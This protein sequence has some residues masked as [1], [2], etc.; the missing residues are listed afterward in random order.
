MMWRSLKPPQKL[1][2]VFLLLAGLPLAG[3]GWLGWQLLERDR[4]Q[5]EG[6]RLESAAVLIAAE[7]EHALGQWD[8]V[9]APALRHDAVQLPAGVSLLV[10]L[11]NGAPRHQGA[12]LAYYPVLARPASAPADMFVSGELYEYRSD[13]DLDKAAAIYRA[14]AK[15]R[16]DPVRAGALM[17]LARVAR[18]QQR[19]R[20]AV[21]RYG[22]LAMLGETVVND[23]PA[24]LVAGRERMALFG[25]L[26]NEPAATSEAAALAAALAQGR[27]AVDRATFD[28]YAQSLPPRQSVSPDA[29]AVR[30]ATALEQVWPLFRQRAEGRVAAAGPHGIVAAWR[31]SGDD[32]AIVLGHDEGLFARARDVAA[33]LG[34]GLSLG[35]PLVAG[36][37]TAP[38]AP[39][40]VRTANETGLPWTMEV[41]QPR[42]TELDAAAAARWRLFAGGFALVVLFM[43]AAAYF[44]FRSLN[45]ELAVAQL[46]SDFVSAVSH[47][48][49]TPLTAMCHLTELLEEGSATADRLPHYYRALGKESRRLQALVESL[50]DFGR[51]ESGRAVYEFLETDAT[52]FVTRTI[53]E[54]REN[55]GPA[56]VRVGLRRTQD[57]TAS[58]CIR[59]DRGAL[60]VALRNLLDNALK[61]S[62]S[63]TPVTVTVDA[64]DGFVRIGLED[65]GAGISRAEPRESFRKFTRGTAARALNVKGTGIG[66]TMAAEIVRAHGGRLEVRSEPGQGSR[67][68]TLLPMRQG[69]A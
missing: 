38:S 27:F 18:R 50:L 14:L 45:R 13:P 25:A 43:G 10:V 34:V 68:T 7:L 4:R 51:I 67:F 31:R 8:A 48:F 41:L 55:A 44:V 62:P 46:Q 23:V 35:D 56:A 15:S 11:S 1:L 57:G 60:A 21:A 53:Q 33:R 47:E 39:R 61:Y 64:R 17:R 29:E 22:E 2:A 59:A 6:E 42:S 40:V 9:L 19:L 12:P 26:G 5:G 69:H 63:S 66:L 28:F 52:E 3:L 65:A 16:A 54:F 24:S 30:L 37:D 58:P 20:D 49:R 36:R 32:T